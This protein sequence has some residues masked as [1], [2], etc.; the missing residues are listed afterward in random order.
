VEFALRGFMDWVRFV[1]GTNRLDFRGIAVVITALVTTAIL[2][3]RPMGPSH[4][5]R[6]PFRPSPTLLRQLQWLA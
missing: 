2:P 4:S 6:S 5:G 1:I 3:P